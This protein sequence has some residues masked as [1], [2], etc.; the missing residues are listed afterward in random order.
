MLSEN[1]YQ[2]LS[3]NP[4]IPLQKRVI[5]RLNKLRTKDYLEKNIENHF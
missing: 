2:L 4:L 3:E 5:N 1:S